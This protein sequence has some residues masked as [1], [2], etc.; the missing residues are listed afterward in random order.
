MTE[1]L[2]YTDSFLQTF[3]ARVLDV[4]SG[5][6]GT[7][8]VF[9]R[10]AFYPTS[11]GQIFDTGWLRPAGAPEPKTRV[12]SVEEDEAT[13]EVL[14]F[15]PDG[16]ELIPG[17]VIEG[18]IDSDRR[19][20]HM[21]QHTGQHVLSAAFEQLY[22]FATVSFHMGDESCTI[23]LATNA[24]TAGQIAA[25]EKLANQ[26][27]FEDRPVAIRFATPDEAR[28]MGVRKIPAAE[29]EKLR[30][31]DIDKFDLNACGGT[32]VR[33]TG[34][35]GSILLRKTEKVRQGVR[36]EFVC[37]MRAVG[38]AR[39]DFTTLTDA[40]AV[41]STHIYD[42]PEQARKVL[43]EAKA[44]QKV[45]SK[46]LEE[47]AELQAA[48]FLQSATVTASGA[49]LVMQFFADARSRVHQDAGAEAYARRAVRRASR[50]RR[51]A[52]VAGI[53]ADSRAG[54][55]HGCADEASVAEARHA[56][57]RQQRH[58]SGRRTG[59]RASRACCYGSGGRAES[60]VNCR[61]LRLGLRFARMTVVL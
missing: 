30:L 12:V 5:A 52:T 10:S 57:R 61:G 38:T 53:R 13:G 15:V 20:D 48:Q 42:L 45:Q 24:V 47:V 56:W 4:R 33:S 39:R 26:I 44:A 7:A 19:R 23:D 17:T 8:V 34:Q 22:N 9:D 27:I 14:H 46:L 50:L 1:R 16:N 25:V 32:H 37:G 29:R 49:K 35:I 51:F 21:Q 55:R 40:A 60:F 18:A 6:N 43:D 11:G 31:I 2:Y 59:R 36:V 41:F 54:E 3:E 28:A 58:G